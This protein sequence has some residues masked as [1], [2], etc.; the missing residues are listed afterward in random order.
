[1]SSDYDDLLCGLG[2]DDL[3]DFDLEEGGVP[4]E[5]DLACANEHDVDFDKTLAEGELGSR[6]HISYL[7]ECRSDSLC[8]HLPAT[9]I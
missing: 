5:D 9:G 2:S 3:N 1:M 7:T 6:V 8:H 4:H